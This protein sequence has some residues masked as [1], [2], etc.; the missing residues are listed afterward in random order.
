MNTEKRYQE[1]GP[2]ERA[3]RRRH[4]LRI[5]Y[6]TIRGW[7]WE[8]FTITH[9]EWHSLRINHSIS[10]GCAQERMNWYLTWDESIASEPDDDADD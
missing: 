4:Y 5:P 1:C 7:V 3:W 8:R 10:I 9:A 6:D 2:L